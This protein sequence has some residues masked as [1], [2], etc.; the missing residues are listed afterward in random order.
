MLRTP[1]RA[2]RANALCERF[3]GSVRR[4]GLDHVLVLGEAH[5]RRVL[6]AYVA[7][8]NAG[9]PPQGIGQAIPSI[10]GL[11]PPS[12]STAPSYPSPCWEDCTTTIAAR[13]DHLLAQHDAMDGDGSQHTLRRLALNLLRQDAARRGSVAT[14]RFLAALDRDYLTTL[15]AAAHLCWPKRPSARHPRSCC[16]RHT[17]WWG[18]HR[19]TTPPGALEEV[20]RQRAR[21]L[22][23]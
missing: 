9:R 12:R 20:P 5:L 3:L 15:L 21:G 19:V 1:I 2:P 7:Y 6:R 18:G 16:P 8:F 4:E 10:P 14:K 13:H 11:A 23:T 17:R 22:S